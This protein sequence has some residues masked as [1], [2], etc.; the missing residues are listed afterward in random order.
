MNFGQN[1]EK[2]F[3]HAPKRYKSLRIFCI[4]VLFSGIT[5]DRIPHLG[6]GAM[7]CT[8]SSQRC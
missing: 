4:T 8:A 6:G 1:Q 3:G 5:V 7:R 2:T